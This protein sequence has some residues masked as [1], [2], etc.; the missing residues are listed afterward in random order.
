MGFLTVKEPARTLPK[1]KRERRAQRPQRLL[2][3]PP[4]RLFP[5]VRRLCAALYSDKTPRSQN[6]DNFL[7][8]A[9]FDKRISYTN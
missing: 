2:H 1:M 4:P 7:I 8:G 3:L 5:Y 9:F 6:F